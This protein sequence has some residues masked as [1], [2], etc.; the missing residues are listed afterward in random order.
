MGSP[1]CQE[2]SPGPPCTPP[3]AAWGKDGKPPQ[4]RTQGWVAGFEAVDSPKNSFI[5]LHVL[6][7]HHNNQKKK[8]FVVKQEH[9]CENC[10]CCNWVVR[11]IQK[12]GTGQTGSIHSILKW[13]LGPPRPSGENL[14]P[15][16]K[17]GKLPTICACMCACGL[18]SSPQDWGSPSPIC[19]QERGVPEKSWE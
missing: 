14:S 16:H 4:H 8:S 15:I 1:H 18:V 6:L 11:K 5:T 3:G 9:L 17:Q 13:D 10:M 12:H 19:I 2:G 7:P